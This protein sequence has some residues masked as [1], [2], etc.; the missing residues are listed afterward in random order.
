[1]GAGNEREFI[2]YLQSKEAA[3]VKRCCRTCIH[4]D[5]EK[6]ECYEGGFT[7]LGDLDEELTRED[8]N[9]YEERV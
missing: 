6:H 2:D 7:E 9:A 5:V 4:C 8:C 3:K 1:M